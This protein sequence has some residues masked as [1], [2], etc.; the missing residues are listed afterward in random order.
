MKTQHTVV[1]HFKNGHVNETPFGSF[2]EAR[3]YYRHGVSYS[4]GGSVTR[5]EVINHTGGGVR[6]VWD[7]AWSVESNHAGLWN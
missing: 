6:A 1:V 2:V 4:E 5:V 7:R 3:Q